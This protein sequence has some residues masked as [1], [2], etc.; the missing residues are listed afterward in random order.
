MQIHSLHLPYKKKT[1]DWERQAGMVL[2]FQV[3]NLGLIPVTIYDSPIP[4]G[5]ILEQSQE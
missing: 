2:A 5:V 1:R 4:T 3:A